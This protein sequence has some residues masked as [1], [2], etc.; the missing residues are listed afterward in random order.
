M[1]LPRAVLSLLA[2]VQ[3]PAPSDV[4]DVAWSAPPECPDREALLA[5]L[6]RRRGRPLAVGE[7]TIDAR[8]VGAPGRGYTLRLT[9]A[10]AAT[11]ELREIRDP[12]CAVL[13]DAAALRAVIMLESAPLVPAPGFELA[14]PDAPPPTAPA[15]PTP[16]PSP[17]TSTP[18]PIVLVPATP[19]NVPEDMSRGPG[20]ALRLLGGAE[21]GATPKPTGAVG[22]AVGLLWP[23]AR[24]ELHATALAPRSE[25]LSPG[26]VQAGLFAGAAHGCGRLGRGA[27][28]FPLCLG[29]ELGALRG[30]VRG[31]PGGRA[32]A[33]L[34]GAAVLGPGLVW[35]ASRRRGLGVG[36]QLV[37][38]PVRP[39]FQQ[40]A[41]DSAR[42]LFTPS[43]A[44][45]R[46]WFGLE[47]RLRD[48]W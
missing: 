45:G 47:L 36:L 18:A 23:R 19:S 14:P 22:L 20:L 37:L 8:I 48:R 26:Q 12:S 41:G 27:L 40:G 34:W 35:H 13:T 2:A 31:L 43:R 25:S 33:G 32:A 17:P 1:L 15:A 7:L 46:L 5:A 21:L 16:T 28:E 3:E 6:A 44:S 24:L 4:A 9:L 30:A 29:L 42:T 38:A 11:R 10:S 39:G